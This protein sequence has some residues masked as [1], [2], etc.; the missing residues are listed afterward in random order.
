MSRLIVTAAA[1]SAALAAVALVAPAAATAA[2]THHSASARAPQPSRITP[3]VWPAWSPP[4]PG[5]RWRARSAA[6]ATPSGY[7]PAD[8]QSAYKLGRPPAAAARSRSSTPTTTRPPRPTSA[9]TARSTACP[10]ARPPT[11]ASARS[12]RP[13]APPAT[14]G[15]NAGWATE[16]SL[17]LDMV[18]AACPSCKILLVEAKTA[19]FAN[20]GTAR[21]LR[22][23]ARAWPRSATATAAATRGADLGLQP[24]GHRRSPPRPA[25]TATAS[26]RP[27]QLRHG[28]RRRRHQPHQGEQH[29]RLDARRR[30]AAPA[31]AARR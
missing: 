5:T 21:E 14:R 17:D 29:P 19:S 10:P 30:G 9:S 12:A 31:A 11:A 15:P 24:P 23:H 13:A 8:I 6:N 7:G 3:P 16:I 22:R 25:T 2:A 27:R 28:G 1:A 18:S 20:L 26:S 4:A